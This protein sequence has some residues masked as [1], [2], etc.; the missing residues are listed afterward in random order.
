M[1]TR[2]RRVSICGTPLNLAARTPASILRCTAFALRPS[3]STSLNIREFQFRATHYAR[4]RRSSTETS[5]RAAAFAPTALGTS[6]HPSWRHNA[7]MPN[8][9][10]ILK[11]EILA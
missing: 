9:A 3:G 1:T 4:V 7:A 11:S 10:Q 2:T 8:I 6:A 5:S